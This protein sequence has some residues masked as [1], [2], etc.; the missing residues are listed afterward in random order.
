MFGDD[1]TDTANE[2]AVRKAEEEAYGDSDYVYMDTPEGGLF[3]QLGEMPITALRSVQWHKAEAQQFR[4][5]GGQ[6]GYNADFRAKAKAEQRGFMHV[7]ADNM[8]AEILKP[9]PEPAEETEMVDAAAAE[10]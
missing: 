4:D 9:E 1:A 7:G 8:V 6:S 3:I 5:F 10:E 2:D